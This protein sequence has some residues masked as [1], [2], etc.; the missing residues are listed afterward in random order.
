LPPFVI[1]QDNSLE[2]MAIQYPI[3]MDELKNIVGVGAG[4]AQK[5]GQPFIDLIKKYVEENEIERPQDFVV[6]SVVNKSSLKVYIIQSID[7]RM[8]FD[9][10][11]RAKGLEFE[12]LLDELES[13]VYSGT[14]INLGY[15]V[16]QLVEEDKLEEIY[17]YF[18]TAE[19]DNIENAIRS[20][21]DPDITD[22]EIRLVRLKFISELAN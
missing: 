7:R 6:K 18:K 13:I 22:E 11:C 1:F 9:D 21:E 2:E 17:E 3:N 8:S 15:A 16:E 5:Y 14:K 12:E 10:I 19:T 20:L 4:K